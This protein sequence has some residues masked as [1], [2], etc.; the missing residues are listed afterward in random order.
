MEARLHKV[1]L[2]IALSN[3]PDDNRNEFSQQ[4]PAFQVQRLLTLTVTTDSN[5]KAATLQVEFGARPTA[6]CPT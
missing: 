3:F 2:T 5:R 1:E 4:A 6:L